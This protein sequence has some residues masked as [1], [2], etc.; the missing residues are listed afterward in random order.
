MADRARLS[1]I[2]VEF[3]DINGG[4]FLVMAVKKGN[5]HYKENRYLVEKY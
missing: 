2:H 1:I 4:S 3:N 5:P